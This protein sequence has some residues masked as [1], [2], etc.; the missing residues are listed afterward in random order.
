A[1]DRAGNTSSKTVNYTVDTTESS[2]PAVHGF[3]PDQGCVPGK[4]KL[5]I[6]VHPTRLKRAAVFLDGKLIASSTTHD[7]KVTI[8]GKRLKPGRHQIKILREYKSGTK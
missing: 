3:P 7:F 8:S 6:S 2:P 4:L 5:K 1:S